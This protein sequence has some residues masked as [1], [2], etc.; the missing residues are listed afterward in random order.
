MSGSLSFHCIAPE[1]II[2]KT[3]IR[4]P[5]NSES[6]YK[7]CNE[8][9]FEGKGLY[10]YLCSHYIPEIVIETIREKIHYSPVNA[11][12]PLSKEYIGHPVIY[13]LLLSELYRLNFNESYYKLSYLHLVFPEE[14][15]IKL[16]LISCCLFYFLII[17]GEIRRVHD[18]L[19]GRWRLTQRGRFN[20]LFPILKENYINDFYLT[21]NIRTKKYLNIDLDD[22]MAM[23]E[24]YSG[25]FRKDE[26]A[27]SLAKVVLCRSDMPF[28]YFL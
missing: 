23:Y 9:K 13:S 12:M 5:K 19:A 7:K 28:S 27:I 2:K 20:E 17:D 3:A 1:K 24:F 10:A 18:I 22:T 26:K 4:N 25:L 8:N 6:C 14:D 21:M 16:E 11:E 15:M